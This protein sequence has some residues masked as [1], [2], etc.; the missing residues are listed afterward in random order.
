MLTGT[1]HRSADGER[2]HAGGGQLLL[3]DLAARL[4][5]AL[6]VPATESAELV[7]ASAA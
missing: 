3:A 1:E 2:P 5:V 6:L 7:K 4:P